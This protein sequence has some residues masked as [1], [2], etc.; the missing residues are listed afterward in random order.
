MYLNLELPCQ[1]PETEDTDTYYTPPR[2][3]LPSPFARRPLPG[4]IYKS[5]C[6]GSGAVSDM[7]EPFESSGD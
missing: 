5:A 3:T 2:L 1:L 6:C 7:Y 4:C